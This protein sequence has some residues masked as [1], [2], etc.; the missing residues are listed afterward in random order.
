MLNYLKAFSVFLLW[1][2]IA[3]TSHYYISNK[4]FN[5]CNLENSPSKDNN[6]KKEEFEITNTSNKVIYNSSEGF[7]I[8]K[9][10]AKVS[11][12]HKIPNLF[13]S[14]KHILTNDYNK[15]LYITG[16][17]LESE[18]E[19]NKFKKIGIQRAEFLKQELI[20]LG[21]DSSKLKVFGKPFNFTYDK[22]KIY[23]NGIEMKFNTLRQNKIDSIELII[24][25]KILYVEFENDSLILNESIKKYLPQLKL[26][27]KKHPSKSISI[28]GHTDNL[29][30]FDKN[31][32]VGLNHA[33]AVKKHFIINGIDT[34]RIK[35]F[36]KGESEPIAD[37]TTEKGRAL[38]RRI[39]LKIN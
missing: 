5:N 12:I 11:S 29:G 23:T 38:N 1:T 6:L 39:E 7:T 30:Y 15:E 21:L 37:K 33:N 20:M 18:L 36:S 14:L 9:H 10:N 31:L 3:L 25:N 27:L 19:K 28:I 32:I 35:T 16:K 26:Y 24:S 22:N 34:N 17:F 2:F 4:H 8:Y 13:D